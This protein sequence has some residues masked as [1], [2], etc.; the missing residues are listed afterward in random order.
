MRMEQFFLYCVL[1]SE[2]MK[3]LG[4]QLISM[5]EPEGQCYLEEHVNEEPQCKTSCRL[6][7][8]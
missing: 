6:D 7:N 1:G 5:T 8:A 2:S 3:H 4:L